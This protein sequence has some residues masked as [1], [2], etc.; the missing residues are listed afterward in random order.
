MHKKMK[1]MKVR[2][3]GV[4]RS[5]FKKMEEAPLQGVNSDEISLIILNR[6]LPENL[7]LLKCKKILVLYWMNLASRDELYAPS[8]DKGVFALRSPGRPNPVGVSVAEVIGATGNAIKVKHLDAI[9]GT[10]VLGLGPWTDPST[11]P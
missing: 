2:A 8:L 3:I 10:P 9:D 4:I 11:R 1:L 5:P 6:P 7:N